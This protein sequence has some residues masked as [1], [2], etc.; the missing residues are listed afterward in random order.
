MISDIWLSL[1]LPIFK[2]TLMQEGIKIE[3]SKTVKY[4]QGNAVCSRFTRHEHV[5][6]HVKTTCKRPVN[7]D[8]IFSLI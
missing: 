8:Q 5:F 2:F 3:I 4:T 7:V 6:K 1:V